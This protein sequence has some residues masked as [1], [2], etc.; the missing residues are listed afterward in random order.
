MAVNMAAAVVE[1]DDVHC[2]ETIHGAVCEC[3]QWDR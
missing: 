1:V 2:G 3:G